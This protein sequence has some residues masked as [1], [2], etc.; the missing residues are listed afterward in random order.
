MGGLAVLFFIA[1]YLVIAYKVYGKFKTSRYKWLVLALIVLI[2]SGDA[3]VGRVYL[4]RM[5]AE[6]GGLKVYR[7]AEHVEGFMD[8]VVGRGYWAK[9]YGYQFSEDRLTNGMTTRYSKHNGQIAQEDNVMPR[10]QY[11]IRL[12]HIGGVKNIYMRNQYVVESIS[13]NETLATDTQIAFNG[14]WAERFLAQFSDAGGGSVAWCT[15]SELY[16]EIRHRRIVISTLK[17]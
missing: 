17:H 9:E 8:D 10:S 5:C 12:L 6:E 13:G 4:K 16:P 3:V 15:N 1:L 2:P 11:R 14:G 7:M